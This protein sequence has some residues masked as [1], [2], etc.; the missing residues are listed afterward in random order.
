MSNGSGFRHL[1]KEEDLN[2]IGDSLQLVLRFKN[3]TGNTI[4]IDNSHHETKHTELTTA[5]LAQ[6]ID[7]KWGAEGMRRDRTVSQAIQMVQR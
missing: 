1:I 3:C 5:R 4:K 2:K 7:S 6:S